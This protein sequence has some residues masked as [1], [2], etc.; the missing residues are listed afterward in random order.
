MNQQN[1]VVN[2]EKEIKGSISGEINGEINGSDQF[3]SS[4]AVVTSL[5]GIC[6]VKEKEPELIDFL[7]LL[8][9]AE[10]K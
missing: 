1:V 10:I 9:G 3:K 5:S 2:G 6:L 4:R 7:T 8:H